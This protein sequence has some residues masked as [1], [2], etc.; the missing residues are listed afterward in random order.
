MHSTTVVRVTLMIAV[1]IGLIS[2]STAPTPTTDRAALIGC[3]AGEDFQPA[4][5]Q[6]AQWVM[7]RRANG[8]F[9]IEFKS[10]DGSIQPEEGT[11][12]QSGNGYTTVTTKIGGDPVDTNDPQFT[13]TYE[14]R[15]AAGGV[16]EYYHAKANIVFKARRVACETK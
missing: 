5:G 8:T 15:S 2:C 11:W 9:S 3:W 14:V 6:S 1:S 16:M 13:D 10:S 12:A 7:N 4:L